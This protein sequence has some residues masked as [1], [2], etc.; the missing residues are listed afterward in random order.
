MASLG[1]QTVHTV[2]DTEQIGATDRLD[3][4]GTCHYDAD[5]QLF[6][7]CG[8][9]D[10]KFSGSS[11][12]RERNGDWWYVIGPGLDD[13]I[14]VIKRDRSGSD[15]TVRNVYPVV[16]DGRGQLIAIAQ[17]DGDLEG[18]DLDNP[19]YQAGFWN[20]SGLTAHAQSFDPRRQSSPTPFAPIS[21]FRN[22]QYDPSTGRWLQ[23]DPIGLSGGANLY[24]YN[25]N[26]P[27]SFSDPFGLAPGC[28]VCAALVF[29]G[30]EALLGGAAVE[31]AGAAV[32][33]A[34][35]AKSGAI[36]AGEA[37]A[38][39]IAGTGVVE[40]RRTVANGGKFSADA[41]RTADKRQRASGGGSLNC[42][43]C[44]TDLDKKNS[45]KEKDHR[46]PFA[47][48]G[49]GDADNLD[50]R[51]RGCNQAKGDKWPWPQPD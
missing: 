13:P 4:Y 25:G 40:Q 5:G 1:I 28:P 32:E 27:N 48:G 41:T 42:P 36:L 46:K 51:C 47:K 49:T 50:F 20:S 14:L 2:P 23:E 6:R 35:V 37:A 16:S 38:A 45:Q 44:G 30:A 34:A 18:T 22:R 21:T 31:G 43:D 17:T 10:L 39:V 9:T 33:G 7:G 26:D 24:Q 3:K 29:E 19:E 8:T 15:T 11:V 12:V